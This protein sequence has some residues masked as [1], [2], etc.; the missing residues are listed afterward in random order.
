MNYN[1]KDFYPSL[2]TGYVN[3]FIH[4]KEEYL[5]PLLFNDKKEGLKFLTTFYSELDTS[6]EFWLSVTY[7]TTSIVATLMNTLI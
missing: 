5:P 3:Q 4:S 6:D 7:V 2:E 1:K